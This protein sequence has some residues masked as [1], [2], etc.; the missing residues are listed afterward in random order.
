[1]AFSSFGTFLK[2]TTFGESHGPAIGGILD[3]FPAGVTIDTDLIQKDLDRRR[4]GQSSI[5]T[6]RDESDKLEILS[7]I[8][9]GK[10]T[11]TPIGFIIRN[12]DQRGKDYSNNLNV[13]RPGHADYTYDQKYGFRDPFGG[14]RSSA[15]ETAVR[16]AAGGFAKHLLSLKGIEINAYVSAVGELSLKNEPEDLSAG[17]KN[18]VRCPDQ[19][20][21]EEMISLIEETRKSGDSI[22]GVVTCVVKNCPAGLG[23]PV[24]DKLTAVLAHAIFSL[25]AVKA[26]EVGSGVKSLSMKGS[27]HNDIFRN[28]EGKISTDSNNSGG[29]NGGIS[30][31]QPIVFRTTFKAVSTIAKVQNTIDSEGNQTTIQGKGRHDPCVVPRAVPMV[32][33]MAA[34]VIADMLLIN[35]SRNINNF[36]K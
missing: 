14:G 21:A 33:A 30:N 25:P 28:I 16:V 31:G 4:P 32:E 34:L 6:R 8:F 23:E 9:E 1:M 3:G 36:L 11:G 18:I 15:R 12:E 22:G 5:T 35:N 20:L 24:F 29:I 10:T 26:F 13:Y 7:G 17:E 19:Q 27:E 2:L